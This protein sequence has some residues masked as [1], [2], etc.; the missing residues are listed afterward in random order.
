MA[1]L[2]KKTA[3]AHFATMDYFVIRLDELESGLKKVGKRL[4]KLDK[5]TTAIQFRIR[6]Y[7]KRKKA[8]K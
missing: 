7:N 1:R 2:K 5:E 4:D 6:E 3:V 8:N